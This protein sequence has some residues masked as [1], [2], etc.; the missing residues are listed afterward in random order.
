MA[1]TLVCSS[2]PAPSHLPKSCSLRAAAGPTLTAQAATLKPV[3]RREHS[4]A[5]GWRKTSQWA[6]ADTEGNLFRCPAGY[7][8]WAGGRRRPT[9]W[10]LADTDLL[11]GLVS[12]KVGLLTQDRHSWRKP[13]L[14]AAMPRSQVSDG[15]ESGLKAD[16]KQPIG[17]KLKL[18]AAGSSSQV[19]DQG[20][21]GL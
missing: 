19:S 10:A 21:T 15:G 20:G 18:R 8:R 13:T 17:C 7:G 16:R 1:Q 12:Y 9:Q 2:W 3:E 4:R 6:R 14:R 11:C 5:G